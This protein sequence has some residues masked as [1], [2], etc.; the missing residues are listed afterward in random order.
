MPL[1]EVAAE[2]VLGPERELQVDPVPHALAAQRGALQALGDDVEPKLLA[3]SVDN[4][5]AATVHGHG[6]ARHR[7]SGKVRGIHPEP[8]AGPVSGLLRGDDAHGFDQSREHGPYGKP[9]GDGSVGRRRL[10]RPPTG[11]PIV[12]LPN[13]GVP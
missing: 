9:R 6:V 3:P 7:A 1:D 2:A 5:Q 8:H 10:T 4:R 11:F 12:G 13:A